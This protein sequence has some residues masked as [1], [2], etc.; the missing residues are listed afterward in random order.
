MAGKEY[1]FKV[2]ASNK[3]TI[4][5]VVGGEGAASNVISPTTLGAPLPSPSKKPV[6]TKTS[7]VGYVTLT[8]TEASDIAVQQFLYVVSSKKAEENDDAWKD[9][10]VTILNTMKVDDHEDGIEY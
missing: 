1:K 2:S 3:D 5:N 6:M 7:E 9:Y 8:W 4:A 10:P